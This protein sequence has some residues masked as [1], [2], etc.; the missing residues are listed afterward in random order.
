FKLDRPAW[1]SEL[2]QVAGLSLPDT[3]AKRKREVIEIRATIKELKDES[4]DLLITDP[5]FAVPE[6]VAVSRKSSS[7]TYN[8]TYT[9]VGDEDTLY[10]TYNVLIPE[11]YRV[12][13]PGA[14]FYMFFGH[15]WYPYLVINFR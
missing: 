5:P 4:I 8:F 3:L 14:H 15:A 7:M 9:N 1:N 2:M 13:K 6:I 10:N 12:L 11:L